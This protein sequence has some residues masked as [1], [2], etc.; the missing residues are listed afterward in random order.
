MQKNKITV[1]K[2][3]LATSIL[4]TAI[5]L[6]GMSVASRGLNQLAQGQQR[7]TVK[8]VINLTVMNYNIKGLGGL[9][10]GNKNTNLKRIAVEIEA[11]VQNGTAPDVILF[12]E[13]FSSDANNMVKGLNTPEFYPY[14]VKGPDETGHFYSSGLVALSRIPILSNDLVV[15]GKDCETWD[16]HAN[17]GAQLVTIKADS[18]PEPIRILNTHMQAEFEF[19][20]VR[21][22]QIM[23]LQSFYAPFENDPLNTIFA[24]DFNTKPNRPS[25]EFFKSQFK[26]LQNVGEYCLK[27]ANCKIHPKMANDLKVREQYQVAENLLLT[28]S[29]DHQF[30]ACSRQGSIAPV[31][32][33]RNFSN[34][35]DG[36][37]LSDHKAYQVTYKVDWN[38]KGCQ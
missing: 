34:E 7:V 8:P 24:G 17:K 30:Y 25:Y 16:C 3:T 13:V 31:S 1:Q 23:I 37:E 5:V 36:L 15:Y 21:N 18:W 28:S 9:F 22:K 20:E 11:K 32:I 4:N 14:R 19:E 2:N 27:N 26:S 38:I 10:G 33:V 12:Q 35:V 6:T 29:K